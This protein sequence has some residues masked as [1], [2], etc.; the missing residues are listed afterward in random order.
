MPA[1]SSGPDPR[2]CWPEREP[3]AEFRVDR[4]GG[5]GGLVPQSSSPVVAQGP[6]LLA[7]VLCNS[8]GVPLGSGVR[9]P[10]NPA[11]ELLGNTLSPLTL[12]SW[13]SSGG[14]E[15]RGQGGDR[16]RDRE[17]RAVGWGQAVS[18]NAGT[19]ALGFLKLVFLSVSPSLLRTKLFQSPEGS[20]VSVSPTA[21]NL[22]AAGCLRPPTVTS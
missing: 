9:V 14:E 12:S 13:S 15:A 21:P 18:Q 20:K 4:G 5:G 22:P 8:T 2:S 16:Q 10:L 7:T 19:S 3:P 6:S 1:P 11:P 17:V